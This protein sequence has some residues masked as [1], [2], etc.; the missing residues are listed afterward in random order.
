MMVGVDRAFRAPHKRSS[1]MTDATEIANRYIALWNEADGG[2]RR[3]LM[4]GTWADGASYVDPLMQGEG[5]D[6]IDGLI[7]AVHQR[8]P[9]HR[10]TLTGNPEGHNDRVR[11]SCALAPE[12]GAAVA[13]V[14][15]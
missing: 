1:S 4:A 9:G 2:R 5:H 8:F 15:Y 13:Q 11:F 14:T 12:G 10:F 7:A 3:A 6:G